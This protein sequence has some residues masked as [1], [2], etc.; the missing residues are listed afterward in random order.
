V[1][2]LVAALAAMLIG[3]SLAAQQSPADRLHGAA[4]EV[5]AAVTEAVAEAERRSL[6]TEPL[7]QKA[8]EGVA[9]NAAPAR[10]VAAVRALLDRL[11]LAATALQQAGVATPDPASIESG[12]F[13]LS[14]GLKTD[15][16]ATL[17]RGAS[18]SHAISVTLQVAGTLAASGVPA[19]QVVELISLA[20][21]S[22]DPPGK[23]LSLPAQVQAA[24]ARGATPA[25]AAAGLAR[26]AEAR[27]RRPDPPRRGPPPGRGPGQRQGTPQRP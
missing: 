6:P 17:A 24:V 9:K 23:L 19:A 3:T 14:A 5:V 15:E 7:V 4:P 1:T 22:G 18:E 12:A 13:A 20:L 2:K 26:A 25:A 10:I 27:A 11:G 21:K 8:V 16:V